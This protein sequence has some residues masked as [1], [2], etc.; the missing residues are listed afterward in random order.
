MFYKLFRKQDE[1]LKKILKD[2]GMKDIENNKVC[3]LAIKHKE[4]LINL[5]FQERENPR[6]NQ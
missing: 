4:E 2:F 1:E 3:R 5:I 6:N